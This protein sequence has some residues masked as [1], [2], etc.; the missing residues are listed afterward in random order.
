MEYSFSIPRPE[1]RTDRGCSG[2]CSGTLEKPSKV[3]EQGGQQGSYRHPDG[4]FDPKANVQQT[5][6][7]RVMRMNGLWLHPEAVFVDLADNESVSPGAVPGK[8]HPATHDAKRY[9]DCI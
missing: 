6:L 2:S 3:Q 4:E 5:V 1:G 9:S 7:F 8:T